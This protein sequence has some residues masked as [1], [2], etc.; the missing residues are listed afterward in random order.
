MFEH[1]RIADMQRLGFDRQFAFDRAGTG[2]V[3]SDG[4]GDAGGRAV[5][6]LQRRVELED[7]VV[8]A[9]GILEVKR[10]RFG[11]GGGGQSDEEQ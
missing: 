10:L 11:L 5:D 6:R 2:G 3:E 9:L 8:D 1:H 4:A 7:H